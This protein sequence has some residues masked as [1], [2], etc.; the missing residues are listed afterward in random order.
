MLIEFQ[1]G[2]Y[3]FSCGI[4]RVKTDLGKKRPTPC[5]ARQGSMIWL[6]R[7]FYEPD[8]SAYLEICFT[9]EHVCEQAL[10][11]ELLGAKGH[12]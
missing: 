4:L 9:K 5:L 8:A 2:S 1:L 11:L 6:G 3:R 7:V 12:C 10:W